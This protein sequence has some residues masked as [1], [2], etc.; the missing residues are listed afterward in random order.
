MLRKA[1]RKCIPLSIRKRIRKSLRPSGSAAEGKSGVQ[2]GKQYQLKNQYTVVSAV[3]NM[4]LYLDDYFESIFGQTCNTANIFFVLVDDGSTDRSAEIIQKWSDRHPGQITYLCQENAGPGAA[5]NRGLQEVTTEWVTFIDSDDKVA[6]NYFEEVDRSIASHPH[7]VM[8]TCRLFYW[9]MA[10]DSL[11]KESLIMRHFNKGKNVYYAVGDEQMPPVFFMNATFFKTDL[12]R[13]HGLSID[14]RLRPNFEDGKFLAQYLLSAEEG[15]VGYLDKAHYYYRKRADQSSLIDRSW[16]DPR[17]YLLVPKLGYL[18]ILQYAQEKLGYVPLN[19]QK[20]ILQD[21]SWF[22][23]ELENQPAHCRKIGTPEEQRDFLNSLYEIFSLIT[24]DAL[25]SMPGGFLAFR[26]KAGIAK[27]FMGQEPPFMLCKLKRLN[28][29][30]RQIL[31]ETF[32][33]NVSFFFDGSKA[34][35]LEVKRAD[36]ELCGTPFYHRYEIWLEYPKGA[37]LFSY[38][39]PSGSEVRLDVREKKTFGR[40]VSMNRLVKLFTKDWDQY[41]QNSR[42]TWLFMDR[43]TQADDNAEHLYRYVMKNHPEQNIAFALRSSSKDWKRLESEGFNLVDFGSPQFEEQLKEASMILSSQADEYVYSYFGD[44]FFD[45]KDFVFLQHGI[46]MNDLSSWLNG[47]IPSLMLTTTPQE[48]SHLASDGAPYVYTPRQIALTGF[49]RH[50]SLIEKRRD[51][52][53]SPE[54]STLLVIPTWRRY[55][56]GGRV[57]PSSTMKLSPTFASSEYKETWE[58]L[59]RSERLKTFAEKQGLQIVFYPHPNVLPYLEAGEMSVPPYVETAGSGTRSFQDYVAEASVCISDYSSAAL[60][61]SL[62]GIPV[63]YYQFDKEKFFGGEH[64]LERGYFD[65]ERDG[66]GPVTYNPE[67]CLA[68][69]E[70]LASQDFAVG[71]PYSERAAATFT[72]A[73]GRCCERAYEAIRKL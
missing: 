47:F 5:R 25:F 18:E 61:A 27:T 20:T 69:L 43:D 62:A 13:Q 70:T 45:S 56:S 16:E 12:I 3:Y 54:R 32:D 38:R 2:A 58:D 64:G 55:L 63:V 34:T 52:T 21:L 41:P 4:E 8:E 28:P 59:L 17:K 40:S 19:I 53:N 6:P 50:D 48:T 57:G 66:F 10:D 1:A 7:A 60:D 36:V 23:K 11:Q 30:R 44:N 35:P 65:F 31:V 15:L 39:M 71:A 33:P 22:F 46:I 29:T 37:Q 9:H 72:M 68:A 73:D 14:E 24:L 51:H 42:N 49:P 26:R 67:Q